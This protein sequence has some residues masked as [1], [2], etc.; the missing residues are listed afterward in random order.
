[1]NFEEFIEELQEQIQERFLQHIEFVSKMV[2]ATNEKVEGVAL[3]FEG[4]KGVDI[5]IYPKRLYEKYKAGITMPEIA[6]CFSKEITHALQNQPSMP[7]ITV[8][9][10]KECI[11]FSLMNKERNKELLEKCPHMDMFDMAAV[12]RWHISD[13]ESFLVDNNIMQILKMTREEL[14]MSAKKNTEN[15][16]YICE[17]MTGVM[18]E[19]MLKNGIEKEVVDE[20]IPM[21]QTP[22]YVVTTENYFDGSAVM[23]SNKFLQNVANKL[24]SDE[25]YIIP[26]S[27]H[28]ILVANPDLP[29]DSQALKEIVQEVNAN[30]KVV[31]TEDFLS[32][33]VYKYSVKNF[34]FSV[35]DSKGLFHDGKGNQKDNEKKDSG[36]G[37]KL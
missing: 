31:S 12:F 33:S 15:Q 20:I 9:N 23:L 25:L 30:S 29:L 17:E 1:M 37:R 16:K 19:I 14:L 7:E 13:R 28:E 32:D 4:Y 5:T 35:C 26:S 2:N 18:R 11:S 24:E 10:A 34:T 21:Q 6:E 22:F 36:K 3:K 27:R 8:E